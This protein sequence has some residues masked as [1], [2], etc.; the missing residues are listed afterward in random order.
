MTVYGMYYNKETGAIAGYGANDT[1]VSISSRRYKEDI[2]D[3]GNQSKEL[4][5]LRPVRFTYKTDTS[6]RIRYG[7]IAEEV[8]EFLPDLVGFNDENTPEKVHY[9]YL[10]PLL[11][12]EYQQQ[13]KRL[14]SIETL[15]MQLN[16]KAQS[17]ASMAQR[18]ELLEEALENFLPRGQ[19]NG[20]E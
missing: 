17:L 6:R 2:Y 9:Q 12:N 3:I 18:L 16:E 10:T 4:L 14:S 20:P 8:A 11:L 19:Q 5:K 15:I 13:E 1:L 7:L